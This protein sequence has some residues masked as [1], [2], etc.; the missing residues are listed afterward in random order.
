MSLFSPGVDGSAKSTTLPAALLEIA[1]LTQVAEQALATPQNRVS[2]SV[3]AEG[4]V[5]T[6]AANIPVTTT[7]GA[8]GS[9]KVTATDYI[10]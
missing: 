9:L 1:Q 7:I 4:T 3:N 5:A 6:I 8:D 2:V 10:V